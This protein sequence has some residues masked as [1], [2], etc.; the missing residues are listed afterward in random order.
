MKTTKKANLLIA[1]VILCAAAPSFAAPSLCEIYAH[2]SESALKTLKTTDPAQD[3]LSKSEQAMIQL[4]VMTN[5]ASEPMTAEQALDEFIDKAGRG[6]NAGKL[7]YFSIVG[8]N[9]AHTIVSVTY[10][11][12]D[13]EYGALFS[14]FHE[15]GPVDLIGLIQDGDIQCLNYVD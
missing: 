6:S 1:S 13:N 12:G 7:H 9:P 14:Q 11:P 15:D 3:R 10:Y 4:A 5:H 2:A 8:Q